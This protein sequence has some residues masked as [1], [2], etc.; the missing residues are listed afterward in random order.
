MHLEMLTTMRNN[1]RRRR[2]SL[3]LTLRHLSELTGDH[4]TKIARWERG[5]NTPPIDAALR[6]AR[7]LHCSVHDLFPDGCE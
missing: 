1:I 7:A 3:D 2:E 6:L 5:E 4:W